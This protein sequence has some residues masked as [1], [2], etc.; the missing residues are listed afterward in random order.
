MKNTRKIE[1]FTAGCPVCE[2]TLKFVREA[3]GSCGCEVVEQRCEGDECC[4]P[5]KRY[6]VRALPTV[7]VDG[8]IIFEGRVTAAQAALLKRGA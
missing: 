2:E 3:V 7:A 4:E 5:A 6:G 1:V 8:A